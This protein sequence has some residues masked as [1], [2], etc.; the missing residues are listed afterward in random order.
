MNIFTAIE[1]HVP[2][3]HGWATVEKATALAA[4]VI[5]LRPNTV[6]EIGIWGGRSLIPIAL[7]MK[8]L[9][10]GTVVGVDPYSAEASTKGMTGE[11]LKWWAGQDYEAM[12]NYF[13]EQV[14]IH[15]VESHV[16]FVRKTS[17][18]FNL[19]EPIGILHTDGNHSD[20][21]IADVLKFAPKVLLGGLVFMDDI[22]W[23]GGGVNKALTT[24]NEL[25]F[26]ELYRVQKPGDDWAVYQR[27]TT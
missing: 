10:K 22:S 6:V 4:S 27:I 16:R 24:L 17:N 12:M 7:A 13:L 2:N 26:I 3:M 20:Q 5:A 8:Q 14:R 19:A 1:Q 21:A 25:G 23:S 18:E 15:G 11:N 9:G